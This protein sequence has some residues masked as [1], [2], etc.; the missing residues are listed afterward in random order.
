MSITKKSFG[1][2]PDG[3]EVDLYTLANANGLTVEVMTYGATITSV[4]TPD[5]NG[6]S[7]NITLGMNSLD[8][9]IA[10]H[11]F[12]GS[13]AGRFANRIAG[14]RFTI[15]GTQYTLATNNNQNHLHGGEVGFDKKVW[16]AETTEEDGAVALRL[17]YESPDGE[18]G[19]P[20]TLS[21]TTTYILSDDDH[22]MM[23]YTATTDKSTHVNLTNHAYWN[24]G[25]QDSGKILDHE[26][27][28]DADNY[29]AVD[30]GSIPLGPLSPV[31]GTEMDFSEL[32]TIGSRIDQTDSGYDH[33]Y[34]LNKEPDDLATKMLTPAAMVHDPASG[35]TMEV[36]TT[37]PGVQLYTANFLDGG[38]RSGGFSNHTGFCLETQ[39]YPDSPNRPEFPSTLLKPGETY[40]EVTVH[41][42]GV[43]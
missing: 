17:T 40:E 7:E 10:G 5:R 15:D 26:L 16:A 43:K 25:G 2:T 35:R 24:L 1:K 18:E 33:C 34:V 32:A 14:G 28:I 22:L 37:Q 11:P 42:F 21:V 19:Y 8:E 38:P 39:H 29:L 36:F 20:G 30:E 13:I 12:F 3:T 23:V 9:Y 4:E 27:I 41:R 31:K 6:K